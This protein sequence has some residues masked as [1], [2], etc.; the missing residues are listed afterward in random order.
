[1]GIPKALPHSPT[2]EILNMLNRAK[3]LLVHAEKHMHI[4]TA[5]DRMIAVHNLDNAVEYLLRTLLIHLSY[6]EWN[7][8]KPLPTIVELKSLCKEARDFLSD[9]FNVQLKY[10]DEVGLI[11][12]LR[13]GIQHGLVDPTRD[14]ERIKNI[15]YRLFDHILSTC[16]GAAISDLTY[17]RL[18]QDKTVGRLLKQCEK[19]INSRN[20]EKAVAFARN[21]F[22]FANVL[23]QY[24]DDSLLDF[25]PAKLGIAD[26]YTHLG[27]YI[28]A[29]QKELSLIKQNINWHHYKRYLNLTKF[30]SGDYRIERS[31]W[32]VKQTPWIRDE[33]EF[34]YSFVCDYIFRNSQNFADYSD[35]GVAGDYHEYLGDVSLECMRQS[36]RYAGFEPYDE[37]IFGYVEKPL[38]RRLQKVFGVV[39]RTESF[40]RDNRQVV[41]GS[42]IEIKH[43]EF[44]LACNY[45]AIW[46]VCIGINTIP[47][48]HWCYEKKDGKIY[49]K[50]VILNTFSESRLHKALKDRRFSSAIC[51]RIVARRKKLGGFTDEHDFQRMRGMSEDM[52]TSLKH[53]TT[54]NPITPMP[55]I[56]RKVLAETA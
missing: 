53:R 18:V 24:L 42:K 29:M 8:A 12:Q 55:D 11:R 16:F 10:T 40:I 26:K 4:D 30:V 37:I 28:E 45:P 56:A 50:T 7:K 21:A 35:T 14:I 34:C 2:P 52:L 25:I 3:A 51:K 15:T 33:A 32:H 46:G 43:R 13:N 22:D 49:N 38:H 47:F 36:C 39:P 31:G 6:D 41:L 44:R 27:N 1:M 19:A 23:L 20:Y 48:T 5:I 17:S 9:R 54:I